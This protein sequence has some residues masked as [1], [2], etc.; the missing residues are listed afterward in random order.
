MSMDKELYKQKIHLL[1][2]KLKE[3]PELLAFLRNELDINQD[4]RIDHIEKYLGLDYSLDFIDPKNLILDVDYSFISNIGLRTQLKSDF[5]EMMRYRYGTR[6]HKSDFVEFCKYA[7]FQIEALTNYFME[8]ASLDD[9]DNVDIEIVK[10]NILANWVAGWKEPDLYNK[11]SID[12]IDCSTKTTAT[13]GMLALNSRL[14][15]RDKKGVYISEIFKNI[16]LARN[17]QSHRSLSPENSEKLEKWILSTPFGE[18]LQVLAIFIE[19]IRQNI[20]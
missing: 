10:Q 14:I 2:E 11:N 7:H 8:A 18:V 13:L 17:S 1:V 4:A 9:D 15:Y 20:E 3:D 5:R 12:D 19:S 6:S 16:R